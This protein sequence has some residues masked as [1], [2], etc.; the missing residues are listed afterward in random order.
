VESADYLSQM[1]NDLLDEAQIESRNMTLNMGFFSPADLLQKVGTSMDVL[2]HNKELDLTIELSP[3]MP[4]TLYGDE[5]R[6]QQII[7]N[8]V[9]NAI[10]FT[11]Q[12]GVKVRVFQ[13][14]AIYWAFQV[15]DT[16]AGIPKDAQAYIFEPFRQVDNSI[17]RENRGTGLGLS[18]TKQLVA[19]MDGEISLESEPGQGSTFTVTLPVVRK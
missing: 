16:G 1:V 12:G 11:Q 13:P 8:L 17:T 15:I 9:G 6:L 2:A 5:R 4:A 18:I 10:K 3:Q 7:I 14:S 19:L